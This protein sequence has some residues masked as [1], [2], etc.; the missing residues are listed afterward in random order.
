MNEISNWPASQRCAG[1]R[2]FQHGFSRTE[3]F[4]HH[5]VFGHGAGR[6]KQLPVVRFYWEGVRTGSVNWIC[7]PSPM[8][9]RR[10]ESTALSEVIKLAESEWPGRPSIH[11]S[12]RSFA[13]LSLWDALKAPLTRTPIDTAI[14][15]SYI[16]PPLVCYLSLAILAIIPQT[17]SARIASW[18]IFALLALR[19]AAS[20]GHVTWQP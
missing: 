3:S 11:Y 2:H 19:A 9:G 12:I 6:G 4:I 13:I 15:A 8:S 16:L 14:F 18:P 10:R 5:M 7:F 17:R 1:F 20:R